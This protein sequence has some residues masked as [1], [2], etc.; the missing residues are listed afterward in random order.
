MS[1]MTEQILFS[2]QVQGVGFRW[3][4]ER[5]ASRLSLRGFVRNLPDGRVEAVVAGSAASIQQ[6]TEKLQEQFGSGITGIQR[7]ILEHANEFTGFTIRR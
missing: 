5:I 3:T 4:T 1:D 6:L 7:Q 2:G